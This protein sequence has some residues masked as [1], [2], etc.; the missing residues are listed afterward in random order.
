MSVTTPVASAEILTVSIF[1]HGFS[2]PVHSSGRLVLN[3]SRAEAAETGWGRGSRSLPVG[4]EISMLPFLIE[5]L[6]KA[7]DR[8][9]PVR[10]TGGT[11][12]PTGRTA[13]ELNSVRSP[14]FANPISEITGFTPERQ[15]SQ[16]LDHHFRNSPLVAGE[17][18]HTMTM[19]KIWVPQANSCQG[20]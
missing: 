12:P 16:A 2:E 20:S 11:G 17:Q 4:V 10:V 9:V 3:H 1:C 18:S 8:S 19:L 15:R 6:V 7:A 5:D 13:T 14:S